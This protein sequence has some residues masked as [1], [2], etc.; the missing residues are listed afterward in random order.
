LGAARSRALDGV[1]GEVA[2]PDPL[3]PRFL[4]TVRGYDCV[5]VPAP[6]PA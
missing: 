4:Q 3:L 1:Q 6:A 5:F 2:E